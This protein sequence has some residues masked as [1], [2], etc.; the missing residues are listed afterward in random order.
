MHE[1]CHTL[2]LRHNFKA[3]AWKTLEEINHPEKS[4]TEPTVG[5]VMDYAPPNLAPKGQTQGAYYTTT[6]GPYDIWAIEY[7]YAVLKDE[8][9]DLAKIAARSGEPGLE[10]LTDEDTRGSLDSDPLSNR[11]D[12][13]KDSLAYIRRQLQ[14]SSE[15][16]PVVVERG[17]KDGEGYQRA[18]QMFGLL[19]R[20]YW[21]AVGFASRFPGGVYVS[22]DHKGDAGKRPPFQAVT[23]AEQREAMKLLTE[24]AFSPPKIDGTKLNYL[25]VSRW[26]HWGSPDAA[27]LDIPIY[28]Q[29]LDGQ[30]AVLSQVMS[31]T[32]LRRI[33]DNEFKSA[34]DQEAYT[35]AEHLR[36]VVDGIFTEW[37]PGEQKG[38]FSVRTPFISGF[39]RNLQREAIKRFA[40]LVT[41]SSG[42]ED[43]RTLAR[44]HLQ[45]LSGQLAA[46]LQ[47]N[48]LKLDDYS[49][50][51]LQDCQ[52]KLTQALE[53]KVSLPNVN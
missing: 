31:S 40:A 46:L 48:D 11:F 36:L 3:S 51:H 14:S 43:A 53:A 32:R 7:G 1:V 29:I 22:R 10:Y 15:L 25:A 38:E 52:A 33:L 39:R 23:V 27:R 6:L 34:A 44:M 8:K 16:L 35:L 37:K 18:T 47:N 50:A 12:L 26:S 9:A 20:E 19:F 5:S 41:Q 28:E 42:P 17:V 2:G 30:T 45:T 13:G 49:R 21:R 4:K 24:F